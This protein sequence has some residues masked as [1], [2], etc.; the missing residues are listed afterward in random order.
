M[1]IMDRYKK[2]SDRRLKRNTVMIVILLIL[3]FSMSV[4]TL[5]FL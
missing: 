4:I 3:L 5:F 1:D 2:E